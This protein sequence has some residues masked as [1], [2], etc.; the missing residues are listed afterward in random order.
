MRK[1]TDSATV[2]IGWV[3]KVAGLNPEE[4]PCYHG[5]VI[6]LL[7]G[8]FDFGELVREKV[9]ALTLSV[10]KAGR[11]VLLVWAFGCCVSTGS[12]PI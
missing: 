2:R 1:T 7:V 11:F 8:Q 3:A 12:C 4:S 9:D 5:S 10:A 6:S